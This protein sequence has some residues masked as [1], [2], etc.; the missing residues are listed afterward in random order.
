MAWEPSGPTRQSPTPA[1]V[2]MEPYNEDLCNSDN[3]MYDETFRFSDDRGAMPTPTDG[4]HS[5]SQ[6]G[7]PTDGEMH[8][9]RGAFIA[10][11]WKQVVVWFTDKFTAHGIPR[12]FDDSYRL[13]FR[14]FWTALVVA[15]AAFLLV[16]TVG[17]MIDYFDY[18][19][20]SNIEYEV[21]VERVF[22]KILVCPSTGFLTS[23]TDRSVIFNSAGYNATAVPVWYTIAAFTSL[24]WPLISRIF[25][26]A[27]VSKYWSSIFIPVETG[28]ACAVFNSNG[29]FKAPSAYSR[30][31]LTL[32]LEPVHYA[33]KYSLNPALVQGWYVAIVDQ[34]VAL[35]PGSIT[36]HQFLLR[37]GDHAQVLLSKVITDQTDAQSPK[38][39]CNETPGYDPAVCLDEESQA[40]EVA[41]CGCTLHTSDAARNCYAM[42]LSDAE[43]DARQSCSLQALTGNSAAITA[44]CLPAC[45]TTRYERHISTG[46]FPSTASW[47]SFWSWFFPWRERQLVADGWLYPRDI[48]NLTYL[49]EVTGHMA[50]GFQDLS[51][52]TTRRE[53]KYENWYS[54]LENV[55]GLWSFWMGFS[56]ITFVELCLV[57][58]VLMVRGCQNKKTD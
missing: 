34:D 55:G 4:S 52:T 44:K 30:L 9:L 18:P 50:I 24:G 54:L 22:P 57:P 17:I 43:L 31:Q 36:A 49:R 46:M 6:A 56:I 11:S 8:C 48:Q 10:V 23:E 1:G 39:S 7:S 47:N 33:N 12:V 25:G 27:N 26:K 20:V 35:S 41:Q 38:F 15:C 40:L 21:E 53:L 16:G 29:E 51:V 13:A 37:P 14:L 45:T 5:A 42:G 58:C 19:T 28:G 32:M 3:L 2:D